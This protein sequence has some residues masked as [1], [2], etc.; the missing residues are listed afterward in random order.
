MTI[1]ELTKKLET[2][3]E[4]CLASGEYRIALDATRLLA[5]IHGLIQPRRKDGG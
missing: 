5:T 4:H 2:L 3:C 1:E